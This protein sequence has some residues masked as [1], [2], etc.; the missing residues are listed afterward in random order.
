MDK[1]KCE[2]GAECA[3]VE[4]FPLIPFKIWHC[5]ECDIDFYYNNEKRIIIS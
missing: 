1:L 2:C 3:R 5:P 4:D